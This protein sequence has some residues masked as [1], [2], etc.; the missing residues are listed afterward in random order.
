MLTGVPVLTRLLR[1]PG[2]LREIS[3]RLGDVVFVSGVLLRGALLFSSKVSSVEELERIICGEC[4]DRLCYVHLRLYSGSGA[5]VGEAGLILHG[6]VVLGAFL[7]MGRDKVLGGDA[8]R[9]ISSLLTEGRVFARAIAYSV[10]Q[11]ALPDHDRELIMRA[12]NTVAEEPRAEEVVERPVA[13]MGGETG[14][15]E[16]VAGRLVR[17]GVP[18]LDVVVAEGKKYIVIDIMCNEDEPIPDPGNTSLLAASI[19]LDLRGEAGAGRIRVTIHHKKTY[20][21]TYGAEGLDAVVLRMLGRAIEKLWS[22]NLLLDRYKYRLKDKRL[23]ISLVL[24]RTT[25]YSTKNIWDIA[26]EI[27]S[28]M[29]KYWD[30]ELVVKAKIGAWGLEAVYAGQRG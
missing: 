25:I 1:D 22:M 16:V 28:E 19:Y 3:G 17:L 4:R 14:L 27:Y 23:E 5:E 12:L 21:F 24:K 10:G 20:S 2:L 30:G 6:E 9:R 7:R 26:R 8:L 11:D 13:G 18:V 29:K 15:E